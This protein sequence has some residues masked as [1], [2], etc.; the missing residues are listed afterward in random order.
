MDFLFFFFFFPWSGFQIP[1]EFLG[2]EKSFNWK[3]E[4]TKQKSIR[5]LTK[6]SCLMKPSSIPADGC[7]DTEWPKDRK[8]GFLYMSCKGCFA[9]L[10]LFCFFCFFVFEHHMY[11]WSAPCRAPDGAGKSPAH[12]SGH[13]GSPM[14]VIRW[15]VRA[16]WVPFS[17]DCLRHTRCVL[18]HRALWHSHFPAMWPGARDLTS[19]GLSLL[20]CKLVGIVSTSM[21]FCEGYLKHGRG[22]SWYNVR[23][24]EKGAGSSV[25]WSSYLCVQPDHN[26]P[27]GG[28]GLHTWGASWVLNTQGGPYSLRGLNK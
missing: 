22:S 19:L 26:L 25:A 13:V 2:G 15:F 28:S 6:I 20:L 9:F 12:P 5:E 14:A 23:F 8:T 11:D 17:S 24:L 27:W 10:L 1:K 3:Q 4:K 18:H 16:S 7:G 21:G